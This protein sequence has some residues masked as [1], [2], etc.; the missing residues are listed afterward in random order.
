MQ[1]SKKLTT[2]SG[3]E[4]GAVPREWAGEGTAP[5]QRSCPLLPLTNEICVKCNWTSGIKKFSDYM[6]VL[7]QQMHTWIYYWQIFP[8]T[9]PF[10]RLLVPYCLL[11]WWC[12]NQLT[13]CD[14]WCG[15]GIVLY[16]SKCRWYSYGPADVIATPSSL[17][18]LK[19][20]MAYQCGAGLPRLSWKRGHS[21]T[22]TT[23]LL[24][25]LYGS[26]DFIQDNLDELHPLSASFIYYDPWHPP[27][28]IYMPDGLF[29]QSLY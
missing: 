26:L 6:L 27:C 5:S 20:R 25:P 3:V 13:T 17:A 21:I 22:T 18:S 23:L 14:E 19:S 2:V 28:S 9:G 8:V 12:C 1:G 15:A 7:Y 4:P 10:Q 24:Q 29:A 11:K 16:G